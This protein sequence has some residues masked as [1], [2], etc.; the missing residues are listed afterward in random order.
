MVDF[1]REKPKSHEIIH[2]K[3]WGTVERRHESWL[4]KAA[5]SKA[6]R[7]ALATIG[8]TGM[9]KTFANDIGG[10]ADTDNGV[11]VTF[12]PDT[13][14]AMEP[15]QAAVSKPEKAQERNALFDTVFHDLDSNQK[16]QA[17]AEVDVFKQKIAAKQGFEQEHL[18]IP[19]QFQSEIG[20][21]AKKYGISKDALTGIVSIE[22]GGGTDVTNKTSGARGIVQLMEKTARGAGMVV[23]DERDDRVDPFLSLKVAGELL[24]QNSDFFAGDVGLYIWAH[25]AGEGT[26]YKGL[27]VYF[28]DVY[29]E[30][31]GNYGE[32]IATNNRAARE[33]AQER[34]IA[35]IKKDH[36]DISK[37]LNNTHV[38]EEVTSKLYD[39]SKDYVY[40]VVAASELSNEKIN[41]V[42]K[43]AVA[44]NP[45]TSPK[46]KGQ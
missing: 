32:A 44:A 7:I 23:N 1:S 46:P 24:E 30:D 20:Q 37:V 11:S 5:K 33:H 19:L 18:A 28:E 4:S 12:L 27:E 6:L 13:A 15:Q 17:R 26:V 25:H 8:A 36:T 40:E 43:I 3:N 22:N 29:G 45:G 2:R 10:G 21:T 9:L 16:A 34:A 42:A 41:Q 38:Q 31:I 35:L 39:N 14:H